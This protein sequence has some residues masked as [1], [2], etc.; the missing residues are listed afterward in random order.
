MYKEIN[1]AVINLDKE[2]ILAICAKNN[3]S[4]PADEK[5]FWCAIHKLRLFFIKG[6]SKK[7]KEES[8]KYLE[9]NDQPVL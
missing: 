2:K 1:D 3:I 9:E 8:R 6:V 7:L 4:I 5:Q